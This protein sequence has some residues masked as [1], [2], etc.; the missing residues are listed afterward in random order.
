MSG[1]KAKAIEVYR[2]YPEK[3]HTYGVKL[4]V[5][6]VYKLD[7]GAIVIETEQFDSMGCSSW[8]PFAQ[9]VPNA[10]DTTLERLRVAA[11]Q[12]VIATLAAKVGLL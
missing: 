10:S 8:R 9:D 7:D 2:G 5:R 4:Q 3:W 1:S 6:A 12:E 11:L